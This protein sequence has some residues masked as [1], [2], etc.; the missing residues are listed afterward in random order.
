M[1]LPRDTQ[2]GGLLI[3]IAREYAPGF[4]GWVPIPALNR[5]NADVSLFAFAPNIVGFLGP[6][7]DPFFM[8]TQEQSVQNQPVWQAKGI[9]FLP[10]SH[11]LD[12]SCA[13]ADTISSLV[14]LPH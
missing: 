6:V 1:F 12:K 8:A 2:S 14:I 9:S 4:Y 11:K 7:D 5:T 13:L 3:A 10:L